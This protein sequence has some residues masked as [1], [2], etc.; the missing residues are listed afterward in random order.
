MLNDTQKM[1]LATYLRSATDPAVVAAV[2]SR[3]DNVLA[4]WLNEDSTFI[5]WRSEVPVEEYRKAIVWTE[6]DSLQAGKARIWEWV[7]ANMTL[8][9][10]ASDPAIRQGLADCWAANSSTRPALLAVAKRVATR[11]E[12]LFASGTG[13]V[14]DPGTLDFEGSISVGDVADALNRY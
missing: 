6:C 8:P 5:A 9:I 10:D 13:T 14:A 11:C 2:A 12:A 7:T 3:T 4:A 1:T